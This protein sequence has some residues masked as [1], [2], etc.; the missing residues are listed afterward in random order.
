MSTNAISGSNQL[1]L[2]TLFS[3]VRV[4]QRHQ[5]DDGHTNSSGGNEQGITLLASLLQALTQAATA[6]P[7]PA[8]PP[9][10]A[11]ASPP[12]ASAAPATGTSSAPS[13]S[14]VQDL[15]AF[16]HDLFYALRHAN[17]EDHGG[18]IVDPRGPA[19]TTSGATSS[20]PATDTTP[21]PTPPA[22]APVTPPVTTPPA[23]GN[24]HYRHHGII[25]ALQALIQDLGSA[26]TTGGS[27]GSSPGSTSTALT[28]LN[29]AFVKL[30][31]DLGGSTSSGPA[32]GSSQSTSALQSFLT[33]FLQDLQ[34]NASNSL[35]PL[36]SSVNTT[37]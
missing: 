17:R 26:Q 34:N 1:S 9:A 23:T 28:R 35:N 6:Q 31:G 20:P 13:T 30:I 14:L 25:S 7:A 18:R 36:G 11:P 2:S 5:D 32:A 27:G 16:L 24:V 10:A 21:A 12:A 3:G 8:A 29:S 4:S 15:Q 22:T 19:V 37:A 33:N